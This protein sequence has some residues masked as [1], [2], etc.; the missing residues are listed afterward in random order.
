[1]TKENT[2]SVLNTDKLYQ[3]QGVFTVIKD[4]GD[5]H[6]TTRKLLYKLV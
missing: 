6:E 2:Y 4:L 5:K 3:L 1:M